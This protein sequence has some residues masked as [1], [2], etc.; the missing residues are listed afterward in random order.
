MPMCKDN[1]II[2]SC[3]LAYVNCWR[4][5]SQY[6]GAEKYSVSGIISKEDQSTVD[7]IYAVIEKV[8]N[9]SVG[10]WGNRI[11][12]NLRI[13]IHDGDE[14]KSDPTFRNALYFT[15]RSKEPPQIVDR[16]V[17]P[18]LD[19]TE[20]YSGCY[21]NVSLVFYGYN[22]SGSRGIGIWLGNIQKIRDGNPLGGRVSA[23]EEFAVLPQDD[24]LQ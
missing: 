1:R 18:I 6:G 17:Q 13:P 22:C 8:K 10:K 9:E 12:Q 23:A 3:R 14:E 2:V 21:A 16:N 20:V 11:P 5:V 7:R 24:F 4:P 15:A 19:Q